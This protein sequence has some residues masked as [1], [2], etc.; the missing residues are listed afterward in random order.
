MSK[1]YQEI[2]ASKN[3]RIFEY[4]LHEHGSFGY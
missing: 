2:E 1:I 4:E 3:N